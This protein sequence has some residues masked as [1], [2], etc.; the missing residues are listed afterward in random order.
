MRAYIYTLP[1]SNSRVILPSA[2]E[3]RA[4][5][6]LSSWRLRSARVCAVTTTTYYYIVKYFAFFFVLLANERELY[7][8]FNCSPL[9][10]LNRL[11]LILLNILGYAA[12]LHTFFD[13]SKQYLS[14]KEPSMTSA[15]LYIY[16]YTY[17]RRQTHRGVASL[18][19]II[20]DDE[21]PCI[22]IP[23]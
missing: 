18:L 8:Y 19:P 10:L 16:I 3:R 2:R 11:L 22:S 13:I 23:I 15:P 21:K 12:R 6:F 5:A 4:P 20:L 17:S 7:E 1:T 14:I 9:R